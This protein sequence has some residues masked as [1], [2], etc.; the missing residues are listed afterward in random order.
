MYD[1]W[2]QFMLFSRITHTFRHV[3]ECSLARDREGSQTMDW[4]V[5]TS[6]CG[7]KGKGLDIGWDQC[8]F[9]IY[10][11]IYEIQPL[12]RRWMK[13]I[14]EVEDQHCV[15]W[16]KELGF[17]GWKNS[18]RQTK[19]LKYSHKHRNQNSINK[20]AIPLCLVTSYKLYYMLKQG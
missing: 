14:K 10:P 1:M 8:Q 11:C 2:H 12:P 9:K 15:D 18:S 16:V 6:F 3:W 20:E 4:G 17:F 13:M 7:R 19:N 5:W